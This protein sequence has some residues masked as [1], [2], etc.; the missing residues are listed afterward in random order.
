MAST[1]I[2]FEVERRGGLEAGPQPGGGFRV[3]AE[4]PAGAP[5]TSSRTTANECQE[6]IVNLTRCLERPA[7]G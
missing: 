4:L 2:L 6:V 7:Q 5:L 3:R 1:V